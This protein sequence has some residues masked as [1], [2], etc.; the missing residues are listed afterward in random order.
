MD[1]PP[2]EPST[3]WLAR[4]A[5]PGPSISGIAVRPCVMPWSCTLAI[6]P[7]LDWVDSMLT[8][9]STTMFCLTAA[10]GFRVGE[11]LKLVWIAGLVLV[12]VVV[13]PAVVPTGVQ[14]SGSVPHELKNTP[15]RLGTATA[16]AR[17]DLGVIAPRTGR[18]TPAPRAPRSM[19]RRESLRGMLRTMFFWGF[20][21]RPSV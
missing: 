20:M 12:G 16:C 11:R 5:P 2:A 6:G 4:P 9:R 15:K 8:P 7:Y 21:A 19:V 17:L 14:N 13:T 18:A 10:S 1:G 3:K